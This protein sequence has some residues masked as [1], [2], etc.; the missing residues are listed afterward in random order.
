MLLPSEYNR[1]WMQRGHM[2]LLSGNNRWVN[3]DANIDAENG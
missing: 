2:M 1:I 3:I